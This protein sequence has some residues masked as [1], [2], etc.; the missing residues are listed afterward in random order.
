[1][2]AATQPDDVMTALCDPDVRIVTTTVTEKGYGIDRASGGVDTTNAVI[3]HDLD[4]KNS[5]IG[6]IGL[7]VTAL[8]KRRANGIPPFTALCCAVTT[9]LTTVH[10]FT[11]GWLISRTNLMRTSQIGSQITS[12]ARPRWWIASL[13]RKRRPL[14]LLLRI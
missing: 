10:F 12:R 11:Q 13:L 4:R 3:A 6:I 1:L 14:V 5:P 2:C 9:C 8:E 7:I